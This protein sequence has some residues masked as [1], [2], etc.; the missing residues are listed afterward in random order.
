[1]GNRAFKDEIYGQFARVGSALSN[2]HRLELLDLLA[3]GERPVEDLAREANM[4]IANTSQHLQALRAARLVA[5]DKRGLRVFYRLAGPDVFDLW[6]MLRS[7]GEQRLAEVDRLVDRYLGDRQE[8]DAIDQVELMRR[9]REGTVTV[10]DAR[11]TVEYRQGHIAGAIN[12][13]VE[14]LLGRLDDVGGHGPVVAYCRGPYC[15]YADETVRLL[16]EHGLPAIRLVD[17]YPE[18]AAAGLPTETGER[19]A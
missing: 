9:I 1:M 18:W 14:D 5:A 7:V 8:M 3:Q 12:V 17:G 4:S 13:P 19:T 16:R 15:V 6:R 2:P 11:P 10:L